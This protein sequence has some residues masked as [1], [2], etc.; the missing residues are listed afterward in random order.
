MP[1][2]TP[3]V[4]IEVPAELA[5]ALRAILE[6]MGQFTRAAV[7]SKVD[8]ADAERVL[9]SLVGELE[10]SA[11]ARMLE[12]LDPTTDFVD[13]D[14]VVYR[15]MD[16]DVHGHYLGLRGEVR[17]QRGLFRRQG[18]RNGPTVVPLDLRAGIVEGRYT[19]AAA[20]L[21][22]TL[23]LEMPS[24][25]AELVCRS[26][27]I[28][29][30]SR[31]AQDRIGVAVGQRWEVLRE[32]AEVGLAETLE[33]PPSATTV[34]VAV[35]RI[36]L[37]MAEARPVTAND[38]AAGIKK[39][40]TVTYRM[41]F[42]GAVTVYDDK[43]E[44][45]ATIRH[46]HIA[47]G[48]AANMEASFR[49]DLDALLSRRPDLLV[50]TLA[51]GAPEMQNILDRATANVPVA[52]RIVDFYHCVEHLAA[53]I[54]GTGR[55]VPDQLADWKEML[56]T[57]PEA[58]ETILLHLRVWERE[59]A[60]EACPPGL[61]G[62]L[63]YLDNNKDR[64]RYAEARAAGL[65]IGSGIVE[66]TGK[67]IVQVRMKRAGARWLPTGAQAIMGLRAAG[68]S[69]GDRWDATMAQVL[70]SYTGDVKPP[71]RKRVRKDAK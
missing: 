49:R 27:G 10:C 1:R 26:A 32:A 68:T 12:A 7:D 31:A 41:A 33:L 11:I 4:S 71:K 55:Y 24:R 16:L 52:A 42:V 3:T 35:D 47:E 63:T 65:P 38:R 18:V 36:S 5:Q 62:A 45:T 9:G 44:P 40:L 20:K 64:L 46:A 21:A 48:G 50:V 23:A 58:A 14:G 13:V 70:A 39:P 54:G 17:V 34:A 53:A 29:P 30:H 19:P 61:H 69:S 66:A 59:Y 22:A 25:S 43:G 15:R 57:E 28:L 2:K 37:P 60:A 51:D 56:L 67:T 8:F 6:H